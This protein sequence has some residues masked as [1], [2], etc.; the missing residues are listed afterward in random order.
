MRHSTN[1]LDNLTGTKQTGTKQARTKR[2]EK[3][4]TKSQTKQNIYKRN[5]QDT[6]GI[7]V[8]KIKIKY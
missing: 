2:Q 7:N 4:Y 5:I 6:K 3:T 8:T 1:E